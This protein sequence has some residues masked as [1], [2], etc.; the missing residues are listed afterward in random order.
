MQPPKKIP[1]PNFDRIQPQ[2]CVNGKL[3]RLHRLINSAYQ[4]KIKPFGLRGSMLSI[5]FIIGKKP[6][7]NQKF[8][9]ET[10]VLDQST[11][12]RDLKKLVN[13]GW[14]R[15][16]KGEDSRHSSLEL[17][18]EGYELLEEIAPIWEALHHKVENIL[19][20]FNIQH[21]D[22]LIKAIQTNL[23][24]LKAE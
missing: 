23:I 15:I 24:D 9:A 6:N 5:L 19:G 21:I 16:N 2:T 12:S 13:K 1:T 17:T 4:S 3:R 8:I 14:V 10:L 20:Q 11:M 18:N 22:V 7:V